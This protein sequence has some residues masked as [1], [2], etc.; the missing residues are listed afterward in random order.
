MNYKSNLCA[1]VATQSSISKSNFLQNVHLHPV[2]RNQDVSIVIWLFLKWLIFWKHSWWR[3]QSTITYTN[4]VL[5]F[6]YLLAKMVHVL[7]KLHN[8]KNKLISLL[9]FHDHWDLYYE[10]YNLCD[11]SFLRQRPLICILILFK[12]ETSKA[13]PILVKENLDH[14][15]QSWRSQ[16]MIDFKIIHLI[17]KVAIILN[18]TMTQNIVFL[19]Y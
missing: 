19:C 12:I 9:F 3:S 16:P 18:F 8:L 5:D 10:S 4:Q 2:A 15:H 7:C 6:Y 13:T 1:R 11:N 17:E 14:T